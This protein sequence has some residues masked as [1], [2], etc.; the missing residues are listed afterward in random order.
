MLSF[1][2][3]NVRGL[4]NNVKRKAIFLFCE[5][6]KANCIFLQE[7]HS[8]EADT[9]FW[10]LQ[11]GDPIFF[12]HGTSHSAGAMILFN[13]LSGKVIDHKSDLKG[14]WQM[15]AFEIWHKLCFG[16]CIWI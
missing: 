8:V 6:Q 10:K 16:M 13:R 15:V 3:L 7:T 11:W 1:L 9:Q 12:S 2:S 14:H 5:E 4:R